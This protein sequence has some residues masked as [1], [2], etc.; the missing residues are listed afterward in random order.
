MSGK[1]PADTPDTDPCGILS[2]AYQG[3]IV[4]KRAREISSG[5]SVSVPARGARD[6]SY[7]RNMERVVRDRAKA[8]RGLTVPDDRR[9]SHR[10]ASAM[11]F[12]AC[13]MTR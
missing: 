5:R 11:L 2:H 10:A 9:K 8:G 6:R 3:S 7:L 13:R 1:F 12:F 4:G